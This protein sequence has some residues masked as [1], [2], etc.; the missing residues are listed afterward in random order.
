[1]NGSPPPGWYPDPAD[2]SR[3]RYWDGSAWPP[4]R[5]RVGVA[6][7]F[8]WVVAIAFV[9]GIVSGTVGMPIFGTI[10]GSVAGL[11]IGIPLGLIVGMVL[12]VAARPSV[13][14]K[15]YRLCVDATFVVLVLATVALAVL[16]INQRALVGSRA[17]YTMIAVVVLSLVAVRPLFRRLVPATPE[18]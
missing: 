9:T 18:S 13:T 3:R 8:G 15:G 2:A 7:V 5:P 17:A 16:W 4:V 14:S 11:A 6:G 10:F 1:M 12:A